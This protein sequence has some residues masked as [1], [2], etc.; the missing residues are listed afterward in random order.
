MI[1]RGTTP[2]VRFS[3]PFPNSHVAIGIVSAKQYG[4][5]MMEKNVQDCDMEEDSVCVKFTQAETLAL[6][7]DTT[8]SITLIVKTVDGDRF[9]TDPIIE[10]VRDTHKDEVI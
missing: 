3:L 6:L 1:I 5:V 8:A 10:K 9:E 2:R 4:E 7:P